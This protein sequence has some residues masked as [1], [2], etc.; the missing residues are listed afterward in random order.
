[1]TVAS[2]ILTVAGEVDATSLDISGDA[3]IDGTLET[4]NLTVGGS[5][6][7]D[8]QVL[9]STGSGVGWEDA[10]GGA[11]SAINNATANELVTI[12]STTTEL[13][14]EANLTFDGDTLEVN[15][16]ASSCTIIRSTGTA[17]D[18]Y[19]H[20]FEAS[21][22]HTGGSIW[23][24][25][26]TNN[27]DGYFGGGKFVIANETMG[28]V[29]ASTAAKFV[30]DGT[31]KVGIGTTSPGKLLQVGSRSVDSVGCIRLA[32]K[33]S[34]NNNQWDI[35]LGN[36]TAGGSNDNFYILDSSNTSTARF[37]IS[38]NTSKIGMHVTDPDCALEIG[39]TDAMSVPVGTTAQ[40]PTAR[41]GMIRYNS[42]INSGEVSNGSAW[43][44]FGSTDPTITS[45]SPT[46]AES[47]DVT[48]TVNGTNFASTA[49]LKIITNS[50]SEITPTSQ[51]FTSA[52][53]MTMV[54]PALS[55]SNDPHDVKIT[56]ATGA[57][58]TLINCLDAGENNGTS[59]K[60]FSSAW[61][62][63][64]LDYASGDYFVDIN[65]DT[66][67]VYINN[68]DHDGAWILVCRAVASSTEHHGAS[69]YGVTD[70]ATPID[71]TS[72]TT[73]CYSDNY[74]NE[75]LGDGGYPSNETNPNCKWWAY[76]DERDQKMFGYN[77]NTF[78]SDTTADGTGWD[79]VSP[80]YA[81]GSTVNLGG[82]YG[83]RGFGDHHS[84]STYYAFNRH[85]SNGGFAHDN[86]TNSDGVFYIRH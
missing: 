83:S 18:G 68:D 40:R 31:G 4:D 15:S 54:V 13:D 39:G 28:D 47:A 50:G 25:S 77:E 49:T 22:T 27:S 82:N 84:N 3:D 64:D 78:A 19:R 52:T 75:I 12:G 5:Q 53:V 58:T 46:T 61:E 35:G 1:M 69:A 55:P 51:S 41:A 33:V 62:S 34:S 38:N 43:I 7:S 10:G 37:M 11:V 71:P 29:D 66:D 32:A 85:N 81:N 65:G 60:P 36:A 23:S 48:V 63:K 80:T 24:M 79:L 57:T 73:M 70:G 2:G 42:T 8:G 76:A 86:M 59:S 44:G 9:T 30:I 67:E 56:L 16:S 17:A 45:I 26:S 74:I 72:T 6:G 20:G 14:A 21:N